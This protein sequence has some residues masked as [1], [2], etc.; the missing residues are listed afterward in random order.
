MLTVSLIILCS[1]S[2]ENYSKF[3]HYS[4]D[5]I[6]DKEIA[7]H[8]F[9]S[10]DYQTLDYII[11][12]ITKENSDVEEYG[13]LFKVSKDEYILLDKIQ[14]TLPID[15]ASKFY[16]NKLYTISHYEDAGLYEYTLNRSEYNKKKLEFTNI[17]MV[18]AIEKVDEDYVYYLS[19]TENI[20]GYQTV[21]CSFS[22]MNCDTK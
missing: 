14:T 22:K 6:S 18:A 3:E 5:D 9:I 4:I 20:G 13:L 16:K 11:I 1:C 7:V 8:S 17:G 2:N 19:S 12:D 21:K 10:E 15:S